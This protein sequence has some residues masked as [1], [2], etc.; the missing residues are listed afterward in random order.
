MSWAGEQQVRDITLRHDL[1]A[2]SVFFSYAIKQHWTRENPL[3]NVEIP[4]DKEAVRMHILTAAEEKRYFERAAVDR[5]LHD[6]GRLIILQGMRPEE[7]TSLAKCDVDLN[8]GQLQ[9][10]KARRRQH[11]GR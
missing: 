4:S 1:H 3:Q 11:A 6:L 7:V 9:I 5:D 8:L 2:L 10:V